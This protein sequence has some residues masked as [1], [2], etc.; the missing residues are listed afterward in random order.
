[1]GGI[2]TLPI[3]PLIICII[4]LFVENQ[5]R[6]LKAE[7]DGEEDN[8]TELDRGHLQRLEQQVRLLQRR[9]RSLD[10]SARSFVNRCILICRP[11]QFIVGSTLAL[12][13]FL[14][15]L[16]LLLTSIDKAINSPGKNINRFFRYNFSFW[17]D[18]IQKN[19][20]IVNVNFDFFRS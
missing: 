8:M 19:N 20:K 13:G 18:I 2:K 14:I 15:F 3:W 9:R 5:I 16:S 6:L 1:M 10:Q 17:G 11:F 4:Q 7:F 12:F